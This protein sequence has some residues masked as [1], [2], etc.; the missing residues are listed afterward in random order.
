MKMFL[1]NMKVNWKTTLAGIA[2]GL[3]ASFQFVQALRGQAT[4]DQVMA[5]LGQFLM[6]IGLVVAKDA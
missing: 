6:A 1:T 5:A 2:T 3:F 4:A